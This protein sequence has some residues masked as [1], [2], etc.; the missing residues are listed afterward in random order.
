MEVVME[1]SQLGFPYWSSVRRRF[2]PES[3]FF[4]SGNI[5]RELLAKQVALDL[6]EDEKQHLQNLEDEEGRKGVINFPY[7]WFLESNK[8]RKGKNASEN[9]FLMFGYHEKRSRKKKT[10]EKGWGGGGV[11][12]P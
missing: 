11:H 10:K 4:T 3:P 12:F 6:T 5:E 8:E 7:V 2:G 9:G 1:E